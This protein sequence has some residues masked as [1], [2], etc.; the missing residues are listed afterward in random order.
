MS[1]DLQSTS[2]DH[3]VLEGK[4]REIAGVEDDLE[5]TQ[6]LIDTGEYD[7]LAALLPR[8]QRL[9][10]KLEMLHKEVDSIR[11]D[12]VADAR[13]SSKELVELLHGKDK[14][15]V[16]IRLRSCLADIIDRVTIYSVKL[17]GR[18]GLLVTLSISHRSSS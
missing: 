15:A 14:E 6:V 4:R 12:T 5:K 17:F 3:S 1:S 9:K 13:L 16:R 2:P 10:A 18:C 11:I 7:A 8:R